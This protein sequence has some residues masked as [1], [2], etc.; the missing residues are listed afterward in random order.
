MIES[1][2]NILSEYLY[3]SFWLATLSSF[4]WGLLSIILSPCHLSSIPLIIGFLSSQ[5]K[6]SLGRTFMLSLTFALGILFTIAIIGIITLSAGRLM[7]DIGPIGNY[8]VAVVF[9]AVGLYLLDLIRLP[10][11]GAKLSGT[12]YKGLVAAL[13]LG[14]IFGIGLG[15][16]T[17]AFMAPVLGVVFSVS[18]T[19]MVLAVSLLATFALGHCLVIIIAGTLMNKVQQYL[20]WSENSKAIKIVKK[21]CGILVILGGIY[22]IWTTI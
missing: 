10:W 6:I 20:N 7:G 15:P 14:L 4:V 13:V 8:L 5:G 18:S 3:Q 16:C 12:K 1:I 2:F 19:D 22:M 21:V 9:F 11:D 17:F